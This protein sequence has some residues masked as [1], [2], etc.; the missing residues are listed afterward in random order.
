MS[1]PPK[2]IDDLKGLLVNIADLSLDPSNAR[3]HPERNV[4]A[5]KASLQMFG[6]RKPIVVQKNGMIVRAGNGNV[7]AAKLLGW[8]QIAAVVVDDDNATATQ[9]AI[10]DNRTGDLAEWDDETLGTLLQGLTD[11]ERDRLQFDRAEFA[12]MLEAMDPEEPS[13]EPEL[14]DVKFSVQAYCVSEAQQAKL[15]E[16]L[17]SEGYEC[18]A[19]M[20]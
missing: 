10:A 8:K 17:T 3:K 6:Q 14:G 1:T 13:G 4:E 15:L 9:Y 12:K 16:Q 2:V 19:L 11:E 5:I 7:T 18:K 20:S